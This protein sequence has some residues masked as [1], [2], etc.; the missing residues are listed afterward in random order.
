MAKKSLKPA[1]KLSGSLLKIGRASRNGAAPVPK[2]KAAPIE[3][4]EA[5]LQAEAPESQAPESPSPESPAPES[6]APAPPVAAETLTPETVKPDASAPAKPDLDLAAFD[7]A[8]SDL[9]M[10]EAQP[11]Q[12]GTQPPQAETQPESPSKSEEPA[13]DAA[14]DRPEET[15]A[16]DTPALG[17]SEP[18]PRLLDQFDWLR[19]KNA[20]LA[21]KESERRAVRRPAPRSPLVEKPLEKPAE[22]GALDPTVPAAES[23]PSTRAGLGEFLRNLR[24]G[25]F[26]QAENHFARVMNLEPRLAKRIL[27]NA[28]LEDLAV[29]CRALGLR[30]L[31]FATI[32]ALL[33][34]A[35]PK[36][37]FSA[38]EGLKGS[39][40]IFESVDREGALKLMEFIPEL[41]QRDWSELK[42][43]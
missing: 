21:R 20:E 40:G 11:P 38:S 35:R 39:L 7:G 12:A 34:G 24:A 36:G 10:A 4:L 1:A 31:E 19:S 42:R 26:G 32:V 18:A 15:P 6:R 29:I 28:E 33:R 41:P 17:E 22:T 2:V 43:L 8:I 37:G 13:E 23:D 3:T 14:P 9:L 25:Q 30:S 16:P 5:P 27:Y